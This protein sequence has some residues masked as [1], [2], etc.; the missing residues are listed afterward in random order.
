MTAAIID[1]RTRRPL[2]VEPEHGSFARGFMWLVA[3]YAF[4]GALVLAVWP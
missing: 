1:I 4:V 3:I 2:V